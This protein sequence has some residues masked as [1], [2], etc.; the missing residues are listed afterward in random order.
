MHNSPCWFVNSLYALLCRGTLAGGLS[1]WYQDRKAPEKENNAF[2]SLWVL[3]L[4]HITSLMPQLATVVCVHFPLHVA[5]S[6]LI[7]SWSPK[8]PNMGSTRSNTS[9]SWRTFWW[10]GSLLLIVHHM[11]RC[12]FPSLQTH[13]FSFCSLCPLPSP[14]HLP[15]LCLLLSS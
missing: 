11:I 10:A 6:F 8:W 5:H 4:H 13:S 9:W 12:H 1:S 15:S 14:F 3:L 2:C 7:S